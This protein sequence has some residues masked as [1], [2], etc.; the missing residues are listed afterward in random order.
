MDLKKEK[1]RKKR[2]EQMIREV[3]QHEAVKKAKLLQEEQEKLN[4]SDKKDLSTISIAVPG[5]ILDNAQSVELRSYLAGQV[6]RAACKLLKDQNTNC[7]K[8][9]FFKTVTNKA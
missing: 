3:E 9:L 2:Q 4:D 1:K 7:S 6:A 5:S 8:I